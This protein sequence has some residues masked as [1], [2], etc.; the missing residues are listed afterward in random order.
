MGAS[1]QVSCTTVATG[2]VPLHRQVFYGAYFAL[3]LL[4]F[5]NN[6]E[7]SL[8]SVEAKDWIAKGKVK[9]ER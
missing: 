6:L 4:Y 5:Q 1:T 3:T 9:S 7:C 2:T 8:G